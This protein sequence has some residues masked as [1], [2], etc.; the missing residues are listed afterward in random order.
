[1]TQ[2]AAESI[3]RPC[4]DQVELTARDTLEHRIERGPLVPTFRAAD[5]LVCEGMDDL[6]AVPLSD[7]FKL[8]ALVLDGLA[9]G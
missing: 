1:V 2:R 8:A 6:P 3:H 4:G 7:S 5:P 9:I